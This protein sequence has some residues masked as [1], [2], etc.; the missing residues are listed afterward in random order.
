ML[1]LTTCFQLGHLFSVY[2]HCPSNIWGLSEIQRYVSTN[3]ALLNIAC[4]LLSA[5]ALHLGLGL[6]G[7]VKHVSMGNVSQLPIAQRLD[8]SFQ[9]PASAAKAFLIPTRPSWMSL[10]ISK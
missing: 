2:Y 9:S 8:F 10:W 1:C 4:A 3:I 6:V 7:Q 5:C